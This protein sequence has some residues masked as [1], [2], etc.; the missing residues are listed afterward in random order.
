M[1]RPLVT[2]TDASKSWGPRKVLDRQSFTFHEGETWIITGRSGCGKTTLLNLIAGYTSTDLGT[3]ECRGTLGYLLQS[4]VL[5]SGLTAAQNL[6]V[7]GSTHPKHNLEDHIK[8]TLRSVGLE[9]R[10]DIPIEFLSGGEQQR[11]HLACLLLKDVQVLLLDEPTSSVDTETRTDVLA[12]V[13]KIF[14]G[15]LR[16][17]VSHDEAISETFSRVRWMSLSE[18]VLN[19]Y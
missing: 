10:Y 7:A 11:V 14:P 1:N 13:K 17:I 9:D 16:I 4:P 3:V 2:L 19:V 6:L 12:L 18:G 15:Q 8:E 5:L